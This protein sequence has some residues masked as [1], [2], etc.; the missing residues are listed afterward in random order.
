MQPATLKRGRSSSAV[1]ALG[2]ARLLSARPALFIAVLVFG[3]LFSGWPETWREVLRPPSVPEADAAAPAGQ[4]WSMSYPFR[5]KITVTAGTGAPAS[6][7]SVAVTFGH[8]TLVT[9]GKSLPSGDDLRMVYW[10]GSTW[11]ELDRLLD[12]A[13]SWNNASTKV[14]FK[15]QAAIGASASDDNY[16][17][18]YGNASDGAPP[19][20]GMNV[21][22]FYDDFSGTTIDTSKWTVTRGTTSVS[23]GILTVNPASSIWAQPTYAFGTDTRWEASIQLGGDGAESSFN[24]HAARDLDTNPWTGNWIILWSD[25]TSHYAENSKASTL[26][27]S[28]GF[29]DTTPTLFHTYVMN[30]EGTTGV[31][32]FQD[33][34]QRALLTTNVPTV[35]LR[36]YAFADAGTGATMWQ[37][38]DWWKVRQYVTPEPTSAIAAESGAFGSVGSFCSANHNTASSSWTFTTNSA[39]LA[40]N[41]LGVIVVATDNA[42]ITDGNTNTHLSITDAAGNTWTKAREFTNAN[43]TS[44]TGVTVSVWYSKASTNLASGA[45]ITFNLNGLSLTAKAATCW[46]FTMVTGNSIAVESG[47]DWANDGTDASA[48]T[49]SGLPNI[50]HLFIRGTGAE[51]TATT[52]T[53]STNY[54]AFTHTS[55]TDG[56]GSNGTSMGARGEFRISPAT[57]TDSTDPTASGAVDHAST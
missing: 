30:R 57:T 50:Q 21:Y 23:G 4:W 17:L 18:Y 48:I 54:T 7:Y 41:N 45:N 36:P 55:S 10:N 2:Y 25:A 37:K 53:A 33:A 43:G 3:W 34:T 51:G 56:T 32:Y 52:Y 31:R 26:T 22:L 12:E 1:R 11:V 42:V 35:S 8:A 9:A 38:Y 29:T 27:D 16:Y 19:A 24:F 49:L 28:A 39:N 5:E 13:S 47:A 40:Q 46:A 20:N 44:S 14:W 15:T 6:G